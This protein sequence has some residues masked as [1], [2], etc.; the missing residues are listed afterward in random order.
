MKKHLRL[1]EVAQRCRLPC[2]YLVDSGGWVALSTP[3]CSR[4][5]AWLAV[6]GCVCCHPGLPL[7]P[8]PQQRASIHLPAPVLAAD[9]SNPAPAGGAALQHQA[10]VFPDKEH[11]GRIFYNQAR[12][13]YNH[14]WRKNE[15]VG[16]MHS[17]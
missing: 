10:N 12:V 2:L 17:G 11:F 8:A 16:S 9:A 3:S 14:G 6:S 1:Q 13:Q 7:P 4:L 5:A 15:L